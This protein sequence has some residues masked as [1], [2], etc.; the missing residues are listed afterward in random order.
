MPA[1]DRAR[2]TSSYSRVLIFQT[3]LA[4]E[5]QNGITF[6]HVTFSWVVV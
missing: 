3:Q 6:D 1:P 4:V 2:L 5:F